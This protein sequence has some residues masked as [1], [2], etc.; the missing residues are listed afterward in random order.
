MTQ[1][2]CVDAI[3]PTRY[4]QIELRTVIG[5]NTG[6]QIPRESFP[7]GTELGGEPSV[8]SSNAIW[9]GVLVLPALNI[10]EGS[11]TFADL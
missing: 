2:A 7:N 11:M 5:P 8:D 1:E 3:Q 4:K 10:G 9:L 6:E